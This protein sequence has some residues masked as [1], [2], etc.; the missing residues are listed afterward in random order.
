MPG[1]S[2]GVSGQQEGPSACL[3]EAQG[4]QVTEREFPGRMLPVFVG[5]HG[6]GYHGQKLT[7]V[8]PRALTRFEARCGEGARVLAS[9]LF[10]LRLVDRVALKV[11]FHGVDAHAFW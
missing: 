6:A 2:K 8:R 7:L 1:G 9:S 11:D 4:A 10:E 5:K 3:D